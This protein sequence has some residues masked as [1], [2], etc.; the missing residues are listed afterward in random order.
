MEIHRVLIAVVLSLAVLVVWNLLFPPQTPDREEVREEER[1]EET[2]PEERDLAPE[3]DPREEAEDPW[4]PHEAQ[5]PGF[6]PEEG[7]Q[8]KVDTP[9]Y[10]ATFNSAG[11]I[12]EHFVLK[13]YKQD[14]EP[15]A[16]MVDLVTPRSLA[17]GPMGITWNRAPTWIE[18]E[19]ALNGE[20]LDLEPGDE[21]TLTFTGRMGGVKFIREMTFVADTYKIQENLQVVNTT[22]AQASGEIA[23]ILAGPAFSDSRLNPTRLGYYDQ[24][25]LS[26]E[27]EGN[28]SDGISRNTGIQWAGIV[29]HYFM[30][31]LV[32]ASPDVQLQAHHGDDLFQISLS[33][34]MYLE[35]ETSQTMDQIYYLGPKDREYL[36]GAPNHLEES[37][38]YG[39]FNLLAQPLMKVLH[40][41]YQYTANYGVAILLL[42]LVIKIIFW[43][44]SHKSYKSMNQM[45]KLQPMMTKIR[46]KHKDDRKAMNEEIM[47]LY[48]TYKVNPLGGCLPILVQI[49]VFIAL[50]QGLL[51]SVELRHAPFISHIPFTDIVWLADLSARDPFYITP[52][53]M[54]ATMFLQQRMA[55]APGDPLQARI[56]QFLPLVFIFIF[57]T[58]PS[59]L[60][61]YWLANNVLSIGQQWYMLR[62]ADVPLQKAEQKAA[63][64]AGKSSRDKEDQGDSQ[65]E[66]Q[67][68][69]GEQQQKSPQQ[70]SAASKKKKKKK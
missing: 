3:P 18:G 33:K 31:T 13:E 17:R 67:E 59:G 37:I 10:Q 9:L 69:P 20:D 53:L 25:G 21:K 50:Y 70:K 2:V 26:H 24:D 57:I 11:G 15:D 64:K 27:R 16:P 4:D 19:W 8:I 35:P 14:I 66:S 54:G 45:K 12:L 56:M 43:P 6:E 5:I 40:F 48:K 62:S 44:L 39:W 46:E 52:L 61:I 23:N 38:Y 60:V 42:T 29:D 58:F 34:S 41:F 55:P 22:E 68:K 1:L 65:E 63:E 30:L 28:L 7:E 51:G 47:R 32:P 36:E 49:P